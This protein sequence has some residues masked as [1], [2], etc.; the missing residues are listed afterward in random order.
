MRRSFQEKL[1][2][3]GKIFGQGHECDSCTAEPTNHRALKVEEKLGFAPGF[4]WRS[5][6]ALR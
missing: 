2:I 4:G 6:S 3:E 1:V 5:A